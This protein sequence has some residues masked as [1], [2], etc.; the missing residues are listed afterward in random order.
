MASRQVNVTVATFID[1]AGR[2]KYAQR[3]AVVDVHPAH[4]ERFD[5]LNVTPG[6]ESADTAVADGLR[7]EEWLAAEKLHAGES[8]SDLTDWLAAEKLH[9]YLTAEK[10]WQS[11]VIEWLAAE[12]GDTDSAIEAIAN[13]AARLD[14]VLQS[15]DVLDLGATAKRARRR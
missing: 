10:Q 15:T 8:H 1:V 11:D 4:V 6:N 13:T 9:E 3:D 14:E 5:R 12:S 7:Y 2:T